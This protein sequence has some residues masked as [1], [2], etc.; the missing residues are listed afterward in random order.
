MDWQQLIDQK[1]VLC[2]L[3]DTCIVTVKC[4]DVCR[5]I[6]LLDRHHSHTPAMLLSTYLSVQTI[7]IG[8]NFYV[9]SSS[10]LLV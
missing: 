10:T 9:I 6:L 7:Q 5:P 8:A 4:P 3:H 2:L 1:S